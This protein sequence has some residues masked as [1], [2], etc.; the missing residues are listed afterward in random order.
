MQI[1]SLDI[2][3][4]NL[5]FIFNVLIHKVYFFC[6]GKIDPSSWPYLSGDSFRL[7]AN[8]VLDERSSFLPSQV[9]EGNIVF[10]GFSRLKYF[11]EKV[12]PGILHPYILVTHNGDVTIDKTW[13]KFVDSKI[14]HWFSQNVIINDKKVTPIPIGIENLDHYNHGIPSLFDEAK[15]LYGQKIP[16]I[17]FGFSISTNP[18]VR[19]KAQHHLRQLKTADEVEG[20]LNAADYTRLLSKYMFV[21]SPPGNGIDCHRTWEAMYVGVIPIV[22]RSPLVE[23]FSSCGLPLLIIDD[24]SELDQYTE[25]RLKKFYDTMRKKLKETSLWMPYWDEKIHSLGEKI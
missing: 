20:R 5:L 3:S 13:I 2:T 17:L 1:Y 21:A 15:R 9:E 16:R 22:L 23:Y 6:S 10:V 24:W 12:H 19:T 11:F 7:L 18:A 14:I 8:H 25:E 4:S